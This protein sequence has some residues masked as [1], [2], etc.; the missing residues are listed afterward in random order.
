MPLSTPTFNQF[1]I[2]RPSL[3]I[4]NCSNIVTCITWYS[5]LQHNLALIVHIDTLGDHS[6]F[7]SS[8]GGPYIDHFLILRFSHSTGR[9][10]HSTPS[11]VTLC[12]TY[13]QMRLLCRPGYR[14]ATNGTN[15]KVE[16][17]LTV[18]SR[19]GYG[20]SQAP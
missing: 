9:I 17:K 20:I 15:W 3:Q 19:I 16:Q 11:H 14:F 5:H 8:S 18:P 13:I 6:N 12:M 1:C 7:F 4:E 2:E 10:K